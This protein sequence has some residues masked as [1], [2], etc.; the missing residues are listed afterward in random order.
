MVIRR[1][2]KK[3]NLKDIR[4]ELGLS[5]PSALLSFKTRFIFGAISTAIIIVVIKQFLFPND[6]FTWG[7]P[8]FLFLIL[9]IISEG[10]FIFNQVIA[11]RYPWHLKVR[12]R[13]VLLLLFSTVWFIVWVI[14]ALHIRPYLY[15]DFVIESNQLYLSLTFFMLFVLNYVFLLIV[16]NYHQSL[17]AVVLDNE[18][19]KQ[20]KLR[21]DY[22]ALQDQI[23]P[24]F[25]FNNISTLIAVIKTNP[26]LAVKM[27]EDVS[28]V[29]RYVLQSKE[30]L[31]VSLD[32]ELKFAKSYLALH[33]V[34][35]G[36]GIQVT[37]SVDDRLLDYQVAPLCLQFLVEN[38]IKHNI[39]TL[40]SPL[41]I[42]VK[43]QGNHVSV[44]NSY[45]PKKTT[46]STNTGLKNLKKRYLFLTS[47]SIV[48]EQNDKYFGVTLPLINSIDGN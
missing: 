3:H 27:A 37:Y 34:R 48:V 8:L 20:E 40:S 42:T 22:V 25:L 5:I 46:Y 21:Q 26:D 38:A 47:E 30:R 31:S 33:K 23:N 7:D 29:Y 13:I 9:F 44:T 18:Q 41:I 24:H 39:A 15:S 17:T 1:L 36:E 4:S 12:K 14:L 28:D 32:E 19:L 35:L 43:A 10:I 2:N 6:P 16:Y 45:N 11:K